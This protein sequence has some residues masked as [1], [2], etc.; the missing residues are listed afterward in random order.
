LQP[1]GSPEAL[2]TY[3]IEFFERTVPLDATLDLHDLVWSQQGRSTLTLDLL[4][5]T[6]QPFQ[7][8]EALFLERRRDDHRR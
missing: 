6:L 4:D 8:I 1:N 3:G 5:P 7:D 2:E